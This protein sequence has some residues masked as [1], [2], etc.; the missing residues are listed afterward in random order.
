MIKVSIN[1][2]VFLCEPGTN[3]GALAGE[4]T[5][6]PLICGGR[7]VCGKCAATVSGE[8]SPPLRRE[9]EVLGDYA[10]A[11]GTRLLCQTSALGDCTVELQ[12]ESGAKVISDGE[13]PPFELSPAF[14]KYGVSVDVGTT[15]LAGRLYRSDGALLAVSGV[16]NPQRT[17]GADVIT[18]MEKA[19]AGSAGQLAALV[20]SALCSLILQMS[21]DAGIDPGRIDGAVITGNTVMLSFLTLTDVSTMTRAPFEAPRLFGETVGASLLGLSALKPDTP[22]Y[23]PPCVSAFVGADAICALAASGILSEECAMLAD[24]G[25]NG[26]ILLKDKKNLFVTSTAAG[27]AFEGAGISMGMPGIAGAIDRVLP[28]SGY[29]LQCRVVGDAAPA[30]ICG[31]GLVDALS[32]LLITGRMDESGLL[33]EDPTELCPGVTL[34]Q[35]DVRAAQLAKSAV[36]A[37]IRTLIHVAG[38]EPGKIARLVLAG[39]FGSSLD[40]RSAAQIGLIPGALASRTV[41]AGNAALAGASMLLL[42]AGEREKYKKTAGEAIL[43]PLAANPYFGK[44]YI[45]R[46]NFGQ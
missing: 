27:P 44:E 35:S 7:G 4:K 2:K 26:E 5:G 41:C 3:L 12:G 34:T 9:R 36:H 17:F 8:V 32:A 10:I 37:G 22:V 15:T 42:S 19:L 33:E 38:T 6:V 46:M 18:R 45:E 28:L 20:R 43:V 23:L 40:A 39:G 11:K 16:L 25:T 14:A 31:S 29:A 30:G 21:R 1:G 24:V 13:T